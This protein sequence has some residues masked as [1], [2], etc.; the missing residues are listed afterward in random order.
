[1]STL[2]D[3]PNDLFRRA[4]AELDPSDGD[5]AR[6]LTAV[7]AK[8]AAAGVVTTAAASAT[9]SVAPGATKTGGL[10]AAL[11]KLGTTTKV[12]IGAVL[13]ATAAPV[14]MYNTHD[15]PPAPS[16]PAPRATE[17]MVA[18]TTPTAVVTATPTATTTVA[19]AV[20]VTALPTVATVK[21]ARPSPAPESAPPSPSAA[22]PV[23]PVATTS[24]AAPP[25]GPDLG[26]ELALLDRLQAAEAAH[27][28]A[29]VRRLA[30]EHAR[31]FPNGAFVEEREAARTIAECGSS[32]SPADLAARFRARFPRSPQRA[33][34]DAACAAH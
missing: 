17:A 27:D 34:V 21:P 32:A 28:A 3:D 13:L 4:R 29:S 23:A 18:R 8:A 12:I 16:A 22:L 5:R 31:L 6:T 9:A 10:L 2:P 24:A 33:R 1:M 20:P 19:E 30:D 11:A 15:A 26:P 14:I 25:K 7:L